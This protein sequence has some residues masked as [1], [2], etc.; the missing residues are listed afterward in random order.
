MS[1]MST[2]KLPAPRAWCRLHHQYRFDRSRTLLVSWTAMSGQCVL[3][4]TECAAW[5]DWAG[6][7]IAVKEPDLAVGLRIP[8]DQVVGADL[9][10]KI[11]HSLE[12]SQS[13][14]H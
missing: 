13:T 8:P 3:I 14:K 5:A 9:V 7:V 12:Q 6:L 4:E 11:D 1:K 10:G 2:P